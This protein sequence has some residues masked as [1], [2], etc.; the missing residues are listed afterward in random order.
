M[1]AKAENNE[2]NRVA[3]AE[4]VVDG[5]DMKTMIQI[6]YDDLLSFY[7]GQDGDEYF[8]RDWEMMNEQTKC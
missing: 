4:K 8:Q 1:A 5:M 7:E 3:L 6:I 2:K